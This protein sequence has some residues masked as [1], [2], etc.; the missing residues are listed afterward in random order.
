MIN[1]SAPVAHF[2]AEINCGL[3]LN[4]LFVRYSVPVSIKALLVSVGPIG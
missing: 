1:I 2:L 3:I 4:I